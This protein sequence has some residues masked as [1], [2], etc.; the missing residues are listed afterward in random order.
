MPMGW[1]FRSPSRW[2][3]CSTRAWPPRTWSARSCFAKRSPSCTG[4][5]GSQEDGTERPALLALMHV[6]PAELAV[7]SRLRVGP[8][9]HAIAA[10]VPGPLHRRFGTPGQHRRA[11]V[12]VPLG[13]PGRDGEGSVL[14][15]GVTP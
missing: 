3:A 8:E 11:L 5:N 14:G 10:A 15:G 1:R 6:G 13:D 2:C 4:S 9:F 12:S 7:G